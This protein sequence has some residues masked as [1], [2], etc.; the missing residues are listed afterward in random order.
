MI[1]ARDHDDPFK[2]KE[3]LIN[4]LPFG[5][6]LHESQTVTHCLKEDVHVS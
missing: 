3:F 6:S 4:S 1:A 2:M 5:M